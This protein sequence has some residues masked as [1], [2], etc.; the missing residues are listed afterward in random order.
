MNTFVCAM[1]MGY[2]SQN[3]IY[4]IE[5]SYGEIAYQQSTAGHTA[6][7]VKKQASKAVI[8]LRVA[9]I[10]SF[11]ALLAFILGAAM[12]SYAVS[13]RAKVAVVPPQVAAATKLVR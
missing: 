13:I 1:L 9:I 11:V 3:E 5:N 12:A 7:D 6:V 10:A 2:L 4:L 8:Q